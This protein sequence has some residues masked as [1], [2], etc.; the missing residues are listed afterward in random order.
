MGVMFKAKAAAF[1][2]L[3]LYLCGFLF[4]SPAHAN[5]GTEPE[6]IGQWNI[7]WE[8]GSTAGTPAEVENDGKGWENA[9]FLHPMLNKPKGVISEW[10]RI[11]LPDIRSNH[12]GL[13]ISE[14]YAQNLTIYLEGSVIYESKRNYLYDVHKVLLPLS[15]DDS[16]ET[17]YLKLE[18][19]RERSGID[20]NIR[21]G[22]FDRLFVSYAKHDAGDLILSSAFLFISVIMLI[23]SFFIR[24]AQLSGWISLSIFILTIGIMVLTYSP[25]L[26]VLNENF[27]KLYVDLFD[28]S[29]FILLPVMTY[30]FETIFG[31]GAYSVIS[32]FRK[33]QVAYSLLCA[34][35]FLFNHVMAF[36]YNETYYFFTVQILGVIMLV[37]IVLLV[38]ISITFSLRGDKDAILFTAGFMIFAGSG[39]A[40]LIWFFFHS[41]TYDFYLWK[42]GMAAFVVVLILILSRKFANN[43]D[44]MIRYSRELELYNNQ[45]QHSEKM[46]I[47]SELAASVAHEVRNPLQVTRGFLQLLAGKTG[48]KERDYLMLAVEELDR[49]SGIITDFLTFAKPQVEYMTVLNVAAELKQIEGIIIPLAHLQGGEIHLDIPDKLFIRGNSSK[50]KQAFINMIKNSI[51]ALNVEGLVLIWAYH[52][53]GEVVIHIKDNGEGMDPKELSKLGEPYFSTKTKGTGLGLMVTFRIIEIMQGK[54]KFISEKGVGTEAIIRFP[55]IT[56]PEPE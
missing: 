13:Y 41:P 54:I 34:A 37:Q 32:R 33:F 20:K 17:I 42:W 50:F 48:G 18:T 46:E 6:K 24:K 12:S 8:Y 31:K 10:I 47:I 36:R 49:A 3:I 16:G 11:K 4:P 29:M 27:G 14:V 25:I 40:E 23:C 30:Y 51:E 45:L 56:D 19:P 35:F 21:I 43:H 26:Y 55:A 38:G 15:L 53:Q 2:L 5:T 28:V 52:S 9:D 44:Q 1:F 22:D 39:I 7:L